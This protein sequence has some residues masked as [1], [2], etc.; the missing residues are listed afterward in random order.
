MNVQKYALN[1]DVTDNYIDIGS[2]KL[3]K[4]F[5]IEVFIK[6]TNVFCKPNHII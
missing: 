5:S 6:I 1:F 3:N 4:S 2:F